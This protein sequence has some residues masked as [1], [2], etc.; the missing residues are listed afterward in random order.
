MAQL[1]EEALQR[2]PQVVLTHLLLQLGIVSCLV[3]SRL[4]KVGGKQP[5]HPALA[6]TPNIQKTS[7]R[8]NIPPKKK[9]VMCWMA[10]HSK[11]L[12]EGNLDGDEGAVGRNGK[13]QEESI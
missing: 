6:G 9:M 10:K 2:Q 8:D 7:P 3:M 11:T 1:V 4:D 5:E 13:Q 12:G